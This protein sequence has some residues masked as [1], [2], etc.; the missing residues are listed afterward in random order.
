MARTDPG[1]SA[2]SGGFAPSLLVRYWLV[3]RFDLGYVDT[4]R[5]DDPIRNDDAV[6]HVGLGKQGR[7]CLSF[8]IVER[9]G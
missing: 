8:G 3:E 4:R 9:S 2:F 6:R 1:A 5:G 7:V